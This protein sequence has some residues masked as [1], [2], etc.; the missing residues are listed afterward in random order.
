MIVRHWRVAYLKAEKETR[1]KRKLKAVRSLFQSGSENCSGLP[2]ASLRSLCPA[3]QLHDEWTSNGRLRF[4][5][6][7][8]FCVIT[9]PLDL[10]SSEENHYIISDL[11][12]PSKRMGFYDWCESSLAATKRVAVVSG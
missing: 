12:I 8:R 6:V 11:P 7:T 3:T 10:S 2:D 1:Q 9:D 4:V 5:L